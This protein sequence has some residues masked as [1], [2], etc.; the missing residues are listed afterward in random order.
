[1]TLAFRV[2]GSSQD[3]K[4]GDQRSPTTGRFH[5]ILLHLI[6]SVG[7]QVRGR[8]CLFKSREA[9]LTAMT[10]CYWTGRTDG[11]ITMRPHSAP[12]ETGNVRTYRTAVRRKS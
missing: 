8:E 10:R 7:C 2:T 1:M 4:T 3:G 11:D 12:P 9:A 6:A 5:E